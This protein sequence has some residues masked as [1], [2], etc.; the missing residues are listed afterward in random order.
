V[1]PA[2]MT[3]PFALLCQ[4]YLNPMVPREASATQTLVYLSTA[5]P[6]VLAKQNPVQW[7]T[8][9]TKKLAGAQCIDLLRID[10]STKLCGCCTMLHKRQRDRYGA[11][12]AKLFRRE[13]LMIRVFHAISWL[14][15][16]TIILAGCSSKT[17]SESA[18]PTPA[19]S[20]VSSE[21]IANY[22]K[23]VLAIEPSRQEAY[24]EIQKMLN[25]EKVP[26]IICTQADSIAALPNRVQDIAVNYC[27]QSK[28]IGE[29]QGLTMA[30]FNEITVKAQSDPDL[31]RRIQN[32]L[33]RL[34]R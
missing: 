30:Q 9:A 5:V 14:V 16:L 28:K 3:N 32:E 7:D 20:A 8:V 6:L 31:Q 17:V 1:A 13:S 4:P 29:G 34:Q 2:F 15:S 21:D 24:S 10:S 22:A 19:V 11:L 12:V 25:H 33:V 27:N 18:T 26:D 23:A